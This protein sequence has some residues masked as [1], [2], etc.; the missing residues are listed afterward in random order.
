MQKENDQGVYLQSN[1]F[2]KKDYFPR[3]AD[4]RFQLSEEKLEMLI[5]FPKLIKK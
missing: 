3:K 1:L 4:L 5:F 2:Y